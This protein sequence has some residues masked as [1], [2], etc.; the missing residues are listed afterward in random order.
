MRLLPA[1]YNTSSTG[2]DVQ[3]IN[4]TI[5]INNI[6]DI[7][8]AKRAIKNEANIQK[9]W[10]LKKKDKIIFFY[11]KNNYLCKKYF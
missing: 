11:K 9:N 1:K 4:K 2:D 10:I 5:K 3:D 7:F 8:M 6:P